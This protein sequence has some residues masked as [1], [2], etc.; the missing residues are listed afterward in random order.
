MFVGFFFNNLISG[1]FSL[2]FFLKLAVKAVP[3]HSDFFKLLGSDGS[4]PSNNAVIKDMKQ[5]SQA[6][7]QIIT[8]LNE[9][10]QS[11]GLS[12]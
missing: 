9:F 3:Y 1:C 12:I 10:Y 11:H 8:V 4:I 6:L 2:T 5:F 7:Y